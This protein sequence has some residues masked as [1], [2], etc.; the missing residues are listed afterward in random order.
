MAASQGDLWVAGEAYERYVGRWSRLVAPIFLDGL[1]LPAGGRW[2]DVGCGTGALS[3]AILGRCAPASVLGIDLSTGFLTLARQQVTDNRA[4]FRPGDARDLPVPDAGFDAVV[5]GLVLNFV[6]DQSKAAAEMLRAARPGG[7]VAA[8]VWDYAEGM[9]MM[10]RFWDAAVALDPAVREKD[11]WPRFPLCQPGP[12]RALFEGAGLREVAVTAIE[13][14]TTFRDFDDFWS[15]FLAGQGPA[16]S[17][18]VSIGE[19]GRAALRERLRASLPMEPD[20]SIRLT[21][22]AWAVRGRA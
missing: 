19:E 17:Y 3:Q 2:L 13:V 5:S 15:P 6:P 1:G 22:R 16:P 11:E 7:T 18:C 10:R 21:A 12:L 9:Q 4:E 14:P 8:Y 20:G